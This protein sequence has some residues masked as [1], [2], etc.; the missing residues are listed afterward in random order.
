MTI[1][2][3]AIFAPQKEGG[4]SVSFPDLPEAITE[5]DTLAEA[6][7]RAAE[8]L[9]LTLDGRRAEGMEIPAPSTKVDGAILVF[10]K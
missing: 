9:K 4:Y 10:G 3:P 1:N 8:V 5:G 2:Y 6:T 7:A